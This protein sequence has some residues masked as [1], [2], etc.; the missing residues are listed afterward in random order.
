MNQPDR[1]PAAPREVGFVARCDNTTQYYLEILPAGF[2]AG[3]RCDLILGLHGHGADRKQF[4]LDPRAECAAFR[5]FAAQHNMIAVTPDYRATTSWM[6][7]KAECDV[8]QIISD[9]RSQYRIDRVWLA[10]GSMGGTSALTFAALHPE[11][12]D[13]VTAM[14]AHA[15]HLEFEGFQADI[16]DSFGGAKGEIPEEYRRRSAEFRSDRLTMPV[17]IT[18]GGNDTIVPPDSALRLAAKLTAR[19]HRVLLIQRP[20][21]GHA[22]TREDAMAAMAFM[23]A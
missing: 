7:P 16:A 19:N 13:G 12:V 9:I 4:A 3:H 21:G 5:A 22:T 20:A 15:N 18:V 17:A 23:I 8:V 2:D 14:N 11:L 6:G 10:G 1:C